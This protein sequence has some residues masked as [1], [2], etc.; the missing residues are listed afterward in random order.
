[1]LID[2][3]EEEICLRDAEVVDLQMNRTTKHYLYL[4][5]LIL[6]TVLRSY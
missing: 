4:T 1:M 6:E 3:V 2:T 5:V